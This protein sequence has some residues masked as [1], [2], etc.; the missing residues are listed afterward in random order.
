MKALQMH[1][2]LQSV[3]FRKI[4]HGDEEGWNSVEEYFDRVIGLAQVALE[5]AD[6]AR[7]REDDDKAR[8]LAGEAKQAMD[9][10]EAI[11]FKLQQ[12]LDAGRGC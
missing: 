8:I 7:A 12:I 1:G 11:K 4:L 9:R 3:A 10:A 6:E 5:K 2:V